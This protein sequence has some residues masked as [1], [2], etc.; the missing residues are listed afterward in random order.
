MRNPDSVVIDVNVT[1]GQDVFLDNNT[2][3]LGNTVVGSNSVIGPDSML[4]DCV[5]GTNSHVLRT[6]ANEAKIGN[7][8]EIGPYTYL[9]PGTVLKDGV[10]LL[11]KVPKFL[12]CLTWEMPLL[13]LKQILELPQFLLTMTE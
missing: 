2:H 6:T 5:V 13:E 11:E 10:K 4:K 7:N 12:I 9:R 3:L 8:C 1:L